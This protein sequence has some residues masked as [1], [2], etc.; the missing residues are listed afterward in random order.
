MKART[1]SIILVVALAALAGSYLDDFT[2]SN[3]TAEAA[4]SPQYSGRTY[5]DAVTVT[6]TVDGLTIRL[7]ERKIMECL[8]S[9]RE[10]EGIPT[11]ELFDCV[12]E[13]LSNKAKEIY[14]RDEADA[15]IDIALDNMADDGQVE[16][17]YGANQWKSTPRGYNEYEK[18]HKME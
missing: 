8:P 15:M 16:F 12:Y 13:S 1:I 11:G 2:V 4:W 6:I 17:E 3:N 5:G 18:K 7:F 9:F 10:D 14:D